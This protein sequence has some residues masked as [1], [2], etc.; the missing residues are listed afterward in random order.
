M[1]ILHSLAESTLP[2]TLTILATY[3]CT[4]A[5][6]QCCFESSPDVQGR[7]SREQILNRITEAKQSFAGL[8]LVVFSG[9][10]AFLLKDDLYAAIELATSF[11]LMTRVVTNASWGKNTEHA[12][13]TAERLK[14]AGITEINISTGADHQEW[15]P[16]ASIVNAAFALTKTGIPTLIT[17]ESETKE[18]DCTGEI[19]RH[20][21]IREALLTEILQIQSN[22][23]MPF[24]EDAGQRKNFL[25]EHLLESGCNQ[26]FETI[27]V[28][29]HS[30]L[31]ACCGL[32][33]EHI[34]EMRLGHI[35]DNFSMRDLFLSQSDDFLKYW[36]HV[37]G[38][39]SIIKRLLGGRSEDILKNVVHICQACVVLHQNPLVREAL[40]AR[41]SEF[42]PEIMTRFSLE[43]SMQRREQEFISSARTFATT[44]EINEI[45]I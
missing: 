37:D 15:V 6:K 33:L 27:V 29:P 36:I 25:S 8:K 11:G 45:S 2:H 14:Q 24:S 20:P 3:Q 23:W 28:T 4:A 22:S 42:V 30:N 34:P 1:S 35:S 32:T 44:I 19:T 16:V 39:Y 10:E 31:S 7:L 38:P 13:K 5:C 18:S 21:M 43:A 17:V 12:F 40:A 26:I 41:Y 9:G